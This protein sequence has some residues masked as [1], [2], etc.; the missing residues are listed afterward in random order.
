MD[1][2]KRITLYTDSAWISPY[3]FSCFVA[4][5]EKGL[6]FDTATVALDRG[7]QHLPEYRDRSLTEKVPALDDGGFWL[8]ESMAIVEYLEDAYPP[9]R[10]PRIL[11]AGIRE[12]ARA[13]Q[14]MSWVRTDLLPL[15][16]ERPT[17]TMFQERATKPLS[18]TAALAAQKLLRIA[19]ELIGEGRTS[20]F[21]TWS[22]ADADLAFM[23]L[24]LV[25]NGYEV[26]EKTR[27]FAEAQRAR[28]SMRAFFE[29]ERPPR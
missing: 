18:E 28:P 5:R 11:P 6:P 4:L 24:R 13:R 20:L 21:E 19:G 7:E 9:P 12:R 10:Y 2:P 22:I 3:V 15:R 16:E 26:P 27:A 14:V 23:L 8:S 17:T 29:R 25:L 1:Q